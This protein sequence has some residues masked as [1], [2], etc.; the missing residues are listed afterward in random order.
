MHVI[1]LRFVKNTSYWRIL[2]ESFPIQSSVFHKQSTS[3]LV[4]STLTLLNLCL[5][6]VDD[7]NKSYMYCLEIILLLSIPLVYWTQFGCL[8]PLQSVLYS[9]VVCSTVCFEWMNVI[10]F[11]LK[12]ARYP[13][14]TILYLKSKGIFKKLSWYFVSIVGVGDLW[15]LKIFSKFFDNKE[16]ASGVLRQLY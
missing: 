5:H 1:G 8:E 16:P 4:Q 2:T 13:P 14:E 9:N 12:K 6:L 7:H 11:L 15:F 10:V 3:I